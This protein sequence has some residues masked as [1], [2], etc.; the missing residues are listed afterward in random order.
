MDPLVLDLE[1][2]LMGAHLHWE[3]TGRANASWLAEQLSAIY[4]HHKDRV[5]NVQVRSTNN[6]VTIVGEKNVRQLVP[7]A[8]GLWWSLSASAS[9]GGAVSMPA[10]VAAVLADV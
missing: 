9:P 1:Q 3:Q 6:S 7:D 2:V 8:N 4:S 5:G 10:G